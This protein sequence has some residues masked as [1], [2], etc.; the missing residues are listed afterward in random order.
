MLPTKRDF[1]EALQGKFRVAATDGLS[2]IMVNSGELHS[3]V[4]GYPGKDHHMPL[5]CQVMKESMRVGDVILQSPPSG[6]GASLIIEYR[7]EQFVGSQNQ[8]SNHAASPIFFNDKQKNNLKHIFGFSVVLFLFCLTSAGLYT[9]YERI[10]SLESIGGTYQPKNI[11]DLGIFFL[12]QIG[13]KWLVVSFGSLI[14]LAIL[15]QL[16]QSLKNK[17]R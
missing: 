11:P 9:I 16:L 15:W 6:Q 12:Y 1:E 14:P 3:T 8:A 2:S 7:L 10:S 5:C 17:G 4:G 13:G